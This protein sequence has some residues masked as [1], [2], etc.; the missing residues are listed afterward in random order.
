MS[1]RGAIVI[2]HE[3]KADDASYCS[4]VIDRAVTPTLV[5]PGVLQMELAGMSLF[6]KLKSGP[7]L[8]HSFFNLVETLCRA[9]LS[10]D[11]QEFCMPDIKPDNVCLE[12]ADANETRWV[13]VDVDDPKLAGTGAENA[14]F[15]YTVEEPRGPVPVTDGTLTM[16]ANIALVLSCAVGWTSP[17]VAD[18]FFFHALE[19]KGSLQ[20]LRDECSPPCLAPYINYLIDG[21]KNHKG[22]YACDTALDI[23]CKTEWEGVHKAY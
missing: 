20:D 1:K 9:A 11:I 14:T 5:A 18:K 17:M 8:G 21:D 12:S 22:S 13:V 2:A 3:T 7:L 6:Q 4:S 15:Q 23:I 19:T 10:A 16:L